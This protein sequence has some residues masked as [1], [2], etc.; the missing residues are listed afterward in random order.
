MLYEYHE[1]HGTPS[2]THSRWY[3]T[4]TPLASFLFSPVHNGSM[5]TSMTDDHDLSKLPYT[6]LHLSNP[7]FYH[8]LHLFLYKIQLLWENIAHAFLNIL[9]FRKY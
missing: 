6:Y 8:Y 5:T 3:N 7:L 4:G 9:P 2:P 1:I